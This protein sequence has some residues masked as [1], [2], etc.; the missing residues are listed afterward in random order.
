MMKGTLKLL[1]ILAFF[2]FLRVCTHMR[3]NKKSPI[4]GK[5]F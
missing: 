4:Y 2:S 5:T 3:D 1:E